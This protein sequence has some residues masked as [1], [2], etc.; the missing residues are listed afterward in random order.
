[1]PA[2]TCKEALQHIYC[3]YLAGAK[4][5][6]GAATS[7]G[8]ISTFVDIYAENDLVLGLATES[9]IQEMID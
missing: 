3:A 2:T 8:R 7:L 4:E 1:M 6:N 9:E 5:N